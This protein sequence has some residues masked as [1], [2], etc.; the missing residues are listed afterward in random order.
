MTEFNIGAKLK[1]LR[2]IRKLTLNEVSAETGFSQ[3]LISQIENDNVSPPIATLS[4]LAKFYDVK[5][6]YFFD[7]N[8]DDCPY[9]VTRWRERTVFP[10]VVAYR[11]NEPRLFLRI[12][13]RA[14]EN[15]RMDPFL[16]TLNEHV[17]DTSTYCHDGEEFLY[18]LSGSAELMLD[19]NRISLD[20]GDGVYFDA[21]LRHRLYATEDGEVKVMA[22]VFGK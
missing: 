22:I 12:P 1:A 7:D 20:A 19:D 11:R 16:L 21:N 13:V 18:V 6:G 10:R 17:S 3:A 5:M 9:E 15:K 14:Q 8:S 2:K 4:R